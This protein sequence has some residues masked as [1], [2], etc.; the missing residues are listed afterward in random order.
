MKEFVFQTAAQLAR[1]IHSREASSV[2]VLEDH[3]RQIHE[4]NPALNAVVTLDEVGARERAGE[5]DEL[6]RGKSGAPCT[7]CP[8]RSKT[9]SRRQG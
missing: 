6:R 5:A 8:S 7:A 1:I 4:H 3:L 9:P 2:E